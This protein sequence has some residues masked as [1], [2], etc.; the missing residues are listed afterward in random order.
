M[1]CV[2]FTTDASTFPVAIDP[3]H[4]TWISKNTKEWLTLLLKPIEE[5][6]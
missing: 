3:L 1:C 2:M 4:I 5:V 6:E